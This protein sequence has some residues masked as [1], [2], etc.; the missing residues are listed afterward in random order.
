MEDEGDA[1]R[2]KGGILGYGK[3]IKGTLSEAQ[4]K[5]RVSS[6]PNKHENI[7]Y[8]GSYNTAFGTSINQSNSNS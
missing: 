8:R 6:I 4:M 1:Y 3:I 5:L 7:I 2:N